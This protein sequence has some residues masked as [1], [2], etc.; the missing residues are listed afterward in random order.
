MSFV[1]LKIELSYAEEV[2]GWWGE[3]DEGGQKVQT[4][5]YK[6]NKSGE[7]TYNRVTIVK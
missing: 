5:S 2:G 6:V 4:F 1:L 3:V 7:A